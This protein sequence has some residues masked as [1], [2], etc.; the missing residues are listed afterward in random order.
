MTFAPTS[1]AQALPQG[2]GHGWLRRSSRWPSRQL[3]A[4]SEA[5][6]PSMLRAEE[7]LLSCMPSFN[8]AKAYSD[9]SLAPIDRGRAFGVQSMTRIG[10]SNGSGGGSPDVATITD[11]VIRRFLDPALQL[12]KPDIQ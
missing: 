12:R 6:G 8:D 7:E 5:H 10:S 2:P 11:H 1:H 9:V 4:R 3:V